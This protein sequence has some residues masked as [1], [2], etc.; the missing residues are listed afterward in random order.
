LLRELTLLVVL[1]AA[2]CDLPR[3]PAKNHCFTKRD[4]LDGYVCVAQR[5]LVPSDGGSDGGDGGDGGDAEA[6][7]GAK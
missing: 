2:G 7:S 1:A 3:D 6:M 5:C 4:C